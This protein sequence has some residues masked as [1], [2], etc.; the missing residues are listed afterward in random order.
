MEKLQYVPMKDVKQDIWLDFYNGLT[1]VER[2][3]W[4]LDRNINYYK[5][6]GESP[7]NAQEYWD[8]FNHDKM[9]GAWCIFIGDEMVAFLSL[10]PWHHTDRTTFKQVFS[11]QED[12]ILQMSTVVKKDYWGRGIGTQL[13]AKIEEFGKEF[14]GKL[15]GLAGVMHN[16]NP[17]SYTMLEKNGYS[18]FAHWPPPKGESFLIMKLLVP[19]KVLTIPAS[20]IGNKVVRSPMTFCLSVYNNLEYMKICIESV[21][22]NSYYIDAPF[23]VYA[24][25]CTDG[26]DEWL[27]SNEYDIEY[28]IEKNDIE[29]GIGGGMFERN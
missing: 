17:G 10:I 26:T 19:H 18:I 4:S 14:Y 13:M 11:L 28:Y 21:R 6:P 16:D 8:A 1:N 3:T 24:E 22:R 29:K 27:A 7:T 15:T 23:V 25:N 5:T 9:D 20:I 2:D 12:F